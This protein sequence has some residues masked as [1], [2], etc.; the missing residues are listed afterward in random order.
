MTMPDPVL[1][2]QL[3]DQKYDILKWASGQDAI[4]GLVDYDPVAHGAIVSA[5]TNSM[6]FF[7]LSDEAAALWQAEYAHQLTE[8]RNRELMEAYRQHVMKQPKVIATIALVIHAIEGQRGEV[9]G[10]V[11]ERAIAA[12]R[13]Y[14]AHAKRVYYMSAHDIYAEPARLIAARISRGDIIG[15]FTAREAQRKGWAG[16]TAPEST[17]AVFAV[18][19]DTDWARPVQ[20]SV[21]TVGGRP[22]KRWQ[23]N[24]LAQGCSW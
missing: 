2:T 11:I 12:S 20:T 4:T 6:P 14:L 13:F 3:V 21:S 24:P 9:S 10:R 23:V 7:R 22:T 15:E 5:L 17:A 18:L 1:H 16:C 19:E 8:A